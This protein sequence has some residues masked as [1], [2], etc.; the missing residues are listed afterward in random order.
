M[1]QNYFNLL[2][3]RRFAWRLFVVLFLSANALCFL[4]SNTPFVVDRVISIAVEEIFGRSAD[5]SR[6]EILSYLNTYGFLLGVDNLWNMFAANPHVSWSYT[7][8]WTE[9]ERPRGLLY[10]SHHGMLVPRSRALVRTLATFRLD[11]YVHQSFSNAQA[12]SGFAQSFC[13]LTKKKVGIRTGILMTKIWRPVHTPQ[14]AVKLGTTM[15]PKSTQIWA[16]VPCL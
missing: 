12:I 8:E 10:S 13:R 11:R 5:V 3:I 16:R 4:K 9:N 14:L 7:V 2:V 1:N 15:G 6:R